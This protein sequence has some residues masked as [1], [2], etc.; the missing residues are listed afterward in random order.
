[1][2]KICGFKVNGMDKKPAPTI[3]D[4]YPDL[5][6]EQ[7][8]EVEDTW[9]RYLALVLRIFERLESQ[10]DLPTANLTANPDAIPCDS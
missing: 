9:E 10:G 3:R 6:D 2:W 5:S 4:L 1:M 7:L 8:A